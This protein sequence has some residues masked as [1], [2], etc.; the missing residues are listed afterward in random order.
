MKRIACLFAAAGLAGTALAGGV[1]GCGLVVLN[2]HE[3]GALT[4]S[5]N[6]NVVIPSRVAYVNSCSGSAVRTVGNATL[7][8]EKLMICGG[9]SLSG[10]SGCTGPVV[11]SSAP[12][13]NPFDGLLAPSMAG[14]SA[15]PEKKITGGNVAI[16][17]GY[18]ANGISISGGAQVS[19]AAGVYFIGHG[20]KI[21]SGSL[22]GADVTI[23]MLDGSLDFAGCSSLQLSPPSSG[24]AMSGVVIFQPAQNTADMSIAGGAEVNIGGTMYSAKGR[25][26]L[27]GNSS[28]VGVGPQMGDLVVA[29]KV[30]IAGTGSVKIGHPSFA[31]IILPKLPLYD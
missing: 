23:V 28:V 8:C 22:V 4:M 25:I 24:G 30:S 1:D 17:P 13:A 2:T 10:N 3:D 27:S 12:F 18:Y 19:M 20:F 29:D 16:G 26:K 15:L 31:A 7:E 11:C 6:A 21:T 9:M 14:L 5:G